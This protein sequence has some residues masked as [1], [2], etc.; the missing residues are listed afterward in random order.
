MPDVVG[1][2]SSDAVASLTSHHLKANVVRINSSKPE[3]TVIAQDP[4]GGVKVDENSKVR[5]NVSSGPK[6]V[7]V[8][9]V[10]GQA[11][12]HRGLGLAYAELRHFEEAL[13]EHRQAVELYRRLDDYAG[14]ARAYLNVARA[15]AQK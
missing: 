8:P 9:D 7:G 11:Y 6:D 10:R 5:I 1:D 3:D 14:T 4:A 12:G 13:A 2:S 15:C